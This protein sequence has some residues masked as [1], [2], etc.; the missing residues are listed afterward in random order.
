MSQVYFLDGQALG[1]EYFGFTDPLTNT[2]KP[3]KYTGTF[4]G[5][6]G[7]YDGTLGNSP[8]GEDKSGYCIVQIMDFWSN[9][10]TGGKFRIHLTLVN[11]RP[12]RLMVTPVAGLLR[13]SGTITFTS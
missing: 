2:W 1:P 5:T 6:N 4:T 7:F 10:L 8:I 12:M 13:I 11:L 9:S 3:K